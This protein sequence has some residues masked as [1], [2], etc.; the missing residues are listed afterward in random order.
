MCHE[1][2]ALFLLYAI[3]FDACAIYV[4]F[5]VAW[6]QLGGGKTLKKSTKSPVFEGSAKLL[7]A[8]SLET[9]FQFHLLFFRAEGPP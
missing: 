9:S 4:S 1:D 6:L 3:T 7:L 8:I 2:T 5:F